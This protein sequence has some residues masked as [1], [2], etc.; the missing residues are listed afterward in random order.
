VSGPLATLRAEPDSGGTLITLSGEVDLS[1]ADELEDQIAA[2]TEGM[3]SVTV[4]L[5]DVTYMDSRGV[6]IVHQLSR[7]L[8][9]SGAVLK[10]LAPSSSFAG[11]VLRLTG[12]RELQPEDD[13]TA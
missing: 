11:G 5:R 1:N 13:A 7:R 12:L 4:D 2:A 8:A 6:R 3:A 10:V 9:S